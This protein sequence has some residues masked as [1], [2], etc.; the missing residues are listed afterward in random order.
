MKP[1]SSRAIHRRFPNNWHTLLWQWPEWSNDEMMKETSMTL[2][3]ILY[4][5]RERLIQ[6]HRGNNMEETDKLFRVFDALL[7]LSYASKDTALI[8]V[9]LNMKATAGDI[10]HG[11]RGK[12]TIPTIE[13]LKAVF[14]PSSEAS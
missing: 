13:E 3:D 6:A 4:G 7:Q 2:Y 1:I 10:L 12:S 9:L 11:A 5:L 8:D 14:A